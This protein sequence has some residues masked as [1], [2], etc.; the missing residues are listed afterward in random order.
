[1]QTKEYSKMEVFL[2]K[3]LY[4]FNFIEVEVLF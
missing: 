4:S 2:E 1:M 3:G